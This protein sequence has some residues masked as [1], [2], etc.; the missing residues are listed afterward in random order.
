LE[1][2]ALLIK[3]KKERKEKSW[4]FPCGVV[5]TLYS[6]IAVALVKASSHLHHQR[7]NATQITSWFNL[8]EC[9]YSWCS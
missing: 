8:S 1:A 3:K 7:T 6:G 4:M 2:V 9:D 5:S